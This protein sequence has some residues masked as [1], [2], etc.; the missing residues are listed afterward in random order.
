MSRVLTACLILTLCGCA[1]RASDCQ[2]RISDCL[3]RC[4]PGTGAESRVPGGVKM[5]SDTRTACERS[6]E[7]SCGGG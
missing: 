1:H 7:A 4:L 2:K 3:S 5:G 6:C